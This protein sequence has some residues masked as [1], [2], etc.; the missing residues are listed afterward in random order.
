MNKKFL[1]A[2]L[3][4][5]LM[6]SSTGTFVSCKD[7]DDD[8]D[9]LRAG[10]EQV[11]SDLSKLSYVKS[12]SYN[13]GKLTIVD[14]E[15]KSTDYTVSQEMPTYSISIENGKVILKSGT[16]VV[17]EA[18]LPATIDTKFDASKLTIGTDGVVM[19]DGVAT[20]VT[21]NNQTLKN[22]IVEKKAEDGSVIGYT[23][24]INGQSYDLLSGTI[25]VSSLSYIPTNINAD[26]GEVAY[27]P[28]I[29]TDDNSTFEKGKYEYNWNKEALYTTMVNGWCDFSFKVNPAGV[30]KVNFKPVG[31]V[32][33]TAYT[34][35]TN[36]PTLNEAFAYADNT[37]TVKASAKN[38]AMFILGNDYDDPDGAELS[39]DLDVNEV[40]TIALQVQNIN[41]TEEADVVTSKY[42]PVKRM[43]VEQEDVK[44]GLNRN[45]AN[46]EDLTLKNFQELSQMYEQAATAT[47]VQTYLD[48]VPVLLE[49]P[50]AGTTE[51]S[52]LVETF[53]VKFHTN[54]A[55]D[56]PVSQYLL[57]SLGFDAVTYKYSVESYKKAEVDQTMR[58][59]NLAANGDITFDQNNT[60]AI[61][62]TPV[63]K[64]QAYIGETLVMS[65][66]LK[67]QVMKTLQE[68]V[69]KNVDDIKDF[70]IAFNGNLQFVDFDQIFNFCGFS[71]AQF[72]E[73]YSTHKAAQPTWK[74]QVKNATGEYVDF[75]P[76]TGKQISDYFTIP[77][78]TTT[79]ELNIEGGALNANNN[80][81][82]YTK[83]I[84][85]PASYRLVMTFS[86]AVTSVKYKNL[87]VVDEFTVKNPVISANIDTKQWKNGNA[88]FNVQAPATGYTPDECIFDVDLN[89]YF[90]SNAAGTI[91]AGKATLKWNPTAPTASTILEAGGATY[92]QATYTGYTAEFEFAGD[93]TTMIAGQTVTVTKKQ[94]KIG[95]DIVATI[96]GDNLELSETAK[97][98]ELL[99]A[100]GFTIKNVLLKVNY[101]NGD[102]NV[103][104]FNIDVCRPLAL[105]KAAAGAFTDAVDLG[106]D[107]E[108]GKI[109]S[110]KDWRGEA[111][112]IPGTTT[113]A[114]KL[115]TFYDVK[116]WSLTHPFITDAAGKLDNSKILT[117][118]KA[119]EHGNWVPDNTLTYE[120]AEV[121]LPVTTNLTTKLDNGK[122]YL[123]YKTNMATVTAA[124][125]MW[126]P[127]QVQ[128]K[129]GVVNGVVEITVNP[130]NK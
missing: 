84:V 98:K 125:K 4:G 80:L 3:F 43:V 21:I 8:I 113:T 66:L 90:V 82:L 111:V 69:V 74:I 2:I 100:G 46:K 18:E 55:Y 53:A 119:D 123:N 70:V 20:G 23:I 108:F 124:Y 122:Y 94:I 34:R 1:S 85:K 71:K 41:G 25:F 12:V 89:S 105:D 118:L 104:N 120:K 47:D 19:Y 31:F 17:S 87:T 6:V 79:G 129:W 65:K 14:G 99:S 60:A 114:E 63:I 56:S 97:T 78:S 106:S 45:K 50:F 109:I 32:G 16:T 10:L 57:S 29:G 103:M 27:F 68:D 5:A 101:S 44:I 95:S 11:T 58:Y 83:E 102:I 96:N 128:Y 126:V 92:V 28:V 35:G 117:N 73:A 15:G 107:I 112:T 59:L 49:V 30:N 93:A 42:V 39:N 24:T 81:V 9:E 54:T 130:R 62:R 52:K 88:Q 26:L 61:E 76:E 22:S 127:V 116:T 110:M 37:L 36:L 67:I 115:G 86:T 64:V 7:Y 91:N 72:V 51:L 38:F 40:N 77:G 121:T 48:Q 13:N 75:V 33:A